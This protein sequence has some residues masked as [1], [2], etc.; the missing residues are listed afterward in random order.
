MARWAD[1]ERLALALPETAEGES[2]GLRQW[3]VKG[4]AFVW[5]RPLRPREIEVLGDAA[6]NGPI[7]AAWVEDLGVKEAMLADDP[8]T[9]FTTS[10]FDNYAIVLARLERLGAEELR[11]L[12][13]EAWLARAPKRLAKAYA[14]SALED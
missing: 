3:Q 4:K 2:R 14:D 11:E 7:L 13:V 5:D 12:V 9:Y 8:E 1:V 10:H 6:P